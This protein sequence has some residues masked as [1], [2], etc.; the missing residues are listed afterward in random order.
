M[1][2]SGSAQIVGAGVVLPYDE[3]SNSGI[4]CWI[5]TKLG[6]F[7]AGSE[8]KFDWVLVVDEAP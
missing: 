2:L 3:P 1:R 4:V 5:A 8:V 7:A 6:I